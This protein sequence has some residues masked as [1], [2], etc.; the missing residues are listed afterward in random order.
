MKA[1]HLPVLQNAAPESGIALSREVHRSRRKRVVRA[2]TISMKR[3]TKRELEQGRLM[4]P[5]L[6]V[7]RP[8]TRADCEARDRSEPCPFVGCRWNLYL[9]VTAKTGAIKLNFPDLE[10]WEVPPTRSCVLDIAEGGGLTL[11]MTGELA[12]LTR[13]R[14]RQVEV[15][16]LAR[17]RGDVE[18]LGLDEDLDLDDDAELPRGR[19]LGGSQHDR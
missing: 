4:Y 10:P 3:M 8:Q 16:A 17:I 11:E 5:D 1:L 14:V 2:Q 15:R 18:D 13:E 9:D 19:V 12:N 6:N 7:Q